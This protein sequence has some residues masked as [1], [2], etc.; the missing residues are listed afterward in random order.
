MTDNSREALNASQFGPQAQAYVK[1]AVH[2][3]GADLDRLERLAAAAKPEH[4]LDLGAGG[5][6]VAYRL[7]AA[8]RRVVA[9]DPSADMLRA[10][11]AEAA[12]RGLD[13]LLTVEAGAENLPF[14]DAHFDFLASRFSTHHW[15]DLPAGLR[16]ARRVLRC[17]APAIF[18]DIVSPGPP[19]LDTH[20]QVVETLRDP[21]H[22]RDYSV[23]EWTA[24]LPAAGFE[25]KSCE[26]WRLRMDFG[27][28]TQ[29]MRTPASMAQAIRDLQQGV[30]SETK[31]YFGIEVDGSFWL[32]AAS[33]VCSAW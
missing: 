9:V 25:L 26:T 22:V 8:A 15:R 30:D 29:R 18:I 2:A 23:A 27:V 14:P 21:S 33:F 24:L 11:A 31:A 19:A 28:W 16:Q 12:R 17:G 20:L 32:D 7:A 10:V 6:H 13:N 5:G 3:G 1:S 4:A